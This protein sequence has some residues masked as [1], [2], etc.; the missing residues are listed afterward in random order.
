MRKIE[1]CQINLKDTSFDSVFYADS[2]SVFSFSQKVLFEFENRWIPSK[3][4]MVPVK[5]T[6][7]NTGKETEKKDM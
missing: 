6:F 5:S 2:E 1:S 3:I 7:L 4:A